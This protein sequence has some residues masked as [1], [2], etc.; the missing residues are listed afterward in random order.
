M[1]DWTRVYSGNFLFST[2]REQKIPVNFD[3]DAVIVEATSNSNQ[4]V[5]KASIGSLTQELFVEG[6]GTVEG[7]R[8]YFDNGFSLLTFSSN[9]SYQL[10]LRPVR[11]VSR[12]EIKIWRPD[13]DIMPGSQDLTDYLR[14]SLNLSDLSNTAT[15]RANLG[16]GALATQNSVTTAIV[17][18]IRAFATTTLPVGWLACDGQA[19][20]RS[21]YSALFVTMGVIWGV[22]DGSTTFNLPDLRRRSL[23]GDGAVAGDSARSTTR[24]LG[25]TGGDER[26]Q[27]HSHSATASGGSMGTGSAASATQ[28]TSLAAGGGTYLGLTSLSVQPSISVGNAGAGSGANMHPFAVVRFAI[29]T[30]VT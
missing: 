17:G 25:Q 7:T 15:A 20:S 24:T 19:V 26:L 10:I 13:E 29:F 12:L 22:G 28:T 9:F 30:G 23:L 11:E 27:Q 18:E 8:R 2:T 1:V 5:S 14:R 16:L 21:T 3:R 4:G 6:F